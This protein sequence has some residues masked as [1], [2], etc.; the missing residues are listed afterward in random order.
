MKP[1]SIVI[2][3]GCAG[4]KICLDI[5]RDYYY[6]RYVCESFLPK[7]YLKKHREVEILPP[8]TN[9]KTLKFLRSSSVEYFVA[10]GD[11]EMRREI[12]QNL[13]NVLDK[14]PTNIVHKS[15]LICT[16]VIGYGNLVCAQA[17]INVGAQIGNG[18]II[19]TNSVV[20]H[21]VIIGNY[22]QVGPGAILGGYAK[23]GDLSFL[24]INS[25]VLPKKEISSDCMVGAGAVVTNSLTEPGTYVGVPC[26]KV[27]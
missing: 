22:A 14:P 16:D 13:I 18:C 12:I 7:E 5:E 1:K 20:E 24:G 3:G 2:I 23:L 8:L 9:K 15:A 19:N 26:R 10:T 25:T 21:D 27:K 4:A 6:T 11:N 17:V